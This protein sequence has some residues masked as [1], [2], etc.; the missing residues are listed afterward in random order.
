MK[1][2]LKFLAVF[3]A[4]LLLSAVLAP[5]IYPLLHYKFERVFNRIVMI[6]TLV[7][8]VLFVRIRH[9]S[10][11]DCGLQW[12][13]DS[14]SL[15]RTAFIAAFLTL[16]IL[17]ALRMP[18]GSSAWTSQTWKWRWIWRIIGGLGSAVLIGIIEEFF[19]RG[20]IYSTLKDK[21]SWGFVPAVMVTNVFY[22]L[23]HFVS[24]KPPLIGPDPTFFDSLRLMAA[25]FA[26]LA[27]WRAIAPGAL[28]LFLFG[29]LLNDLVI[30]TKSL[31]PAIGLHAGGVFF[32]K[33]DGFFVDSI[34]TNPI[35]FGTN[36]IIDGLLGWMGLL[37]LA[38][39]LRVRIRTAESAVKWEGESLK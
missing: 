11:Q 20:F 16:I 36:Q 9:A 19:F 30:R 3:S 32:L 12:K 27:D 10:F 15:F 33:I 14:F 7:A 4:I 31:Y 8:V 5:L 28:G 13:S 1:S 23:V 29:L 34:N 24:E 38:G 21:L 22:S 2:F 18:V 39:F 25:P 6:L 26:A 17:T 37:V 35:F